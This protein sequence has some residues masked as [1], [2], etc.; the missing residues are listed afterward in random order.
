MFKV[1]SQWLNLSL[2]TLSISLL[3]SQ[4]AVSL[5]DANQQNTRF[6]NGVLDSSQ[7]G[8][9]RS[10]QSQTSAINQVTSVSE[11][12]DVEPTE[13]AY[14]AL[15]S[16]V[17]RYGCIVGYPDRTFRGNRALTRWEFAAGLNAC[18][19]VMERLIQENVAVLQEDIDKLKRLAEEFQAELAALGAR[20]DNLES[21]VSFLEDNQFST[22]TKLTGEVVMALSGIASGD[23]FQ[24]TERIP[25]IPTVGHRTR[26]ELNTSFTGE[27]L[28]YTRLATGTMAD[29]TE[30]AGTF[31]AATG[32]AQPDDGDLAV[33]VLFYNFP[34][35]DNVQVVAGPAGVAF[36]DFT[37]TLNVLDGDGATGAISSFGTRNPIYYQGEGG[38]GGLQANFGPLEVSAGYLAGDGAD[39]SEGNGLFNGAYG[40]IAQVGYVPS[41][42]FGVA[43]VYAHGYNTLGTGTGTNRSNFTDFGQAVG[44]E[45]TGLDEVED[46]KTSHNSYGLTFSW[47][48]FDNFVLGG[49]GGFTTAKTLNSVDFFMDDVEDQDP[50]T[51]SRGDLDIWQWAVTLAFPDLFKEGSMAGIVVGMQPW[52]SNS[53]PLFDGN[54]VNEGD[55]SYHIEAFYEYVVTDNISITPG[56]IVVTSPDFS[57]SNSTLVIG[58]IRTTFTF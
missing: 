39:P 6:H 26:L 43:F 21:R 14:E 11:L 38:G 5:P 3:S 18:M 25:R 16:L 8:Y 1:S 51:I 57:D 58:T 15:R 34:I 35:G 46:I 55:S 10:P 23:R 56:V 4:S 50:F 52:V 19:N 45:I 53:S 33:E 29:F 9:L 54:L 2:L 27:D 32:F 41:E 28:L 7:S 30:E 24:G 49:W 22:T 36:D 44:Q 40:A 13:W 20:V 47:Q 12:R 48:V 37:N 42:T 31:Q 17:E